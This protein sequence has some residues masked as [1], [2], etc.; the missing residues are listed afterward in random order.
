MQTSSQTQP[1]RRYRRYRVVGVLPAL[2]IVAGGLYLGTSTGNWIPLAAGLLFLLVCAG[3]I[4]YD[5]R[6]SRSRSSRG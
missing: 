1:R 4:A 6:S 3:M 2:V 5:S